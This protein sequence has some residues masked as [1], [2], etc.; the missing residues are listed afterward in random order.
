MFV[1]GGDV[2]PGD[3]LD[4]AGNYGVYWSSVGYYSY[5]AYYLYFSPY[6]VRPSYDD[7]RY[8]GFSVRCVALS[9]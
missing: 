8:N 4:G 1:R 9:G 3:Y 5:S 7:A 6:G 2:G